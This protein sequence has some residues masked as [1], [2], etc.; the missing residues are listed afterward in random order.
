MTDTLSR[1][2]SVCAWLRS[3]RYN[4]VGERELQDGLARALDDGGYTFRREHRLGPG[5]VVDFLIDP[6]IGLEAKV[7]G[8]VSLVTRQLLR[9]AQH[10]EIAALLLVTSLSRH[11]NLPAEMNGKPVRVVVLRT[12]V[13]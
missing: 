12:G 6:G 9:Y 10:E 11:D 8:S 2:E 4:F 5:D 1:L 3:Y 13:L 7:D